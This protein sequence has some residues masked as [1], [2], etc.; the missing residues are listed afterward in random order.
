MYGTHAVKAMWERKKE[1]KKVRERET[2]HM[3]TNRGWKAFKS[4]KT[5]EKI[6]DQK[7]WNKKI[8]QKDLFFY[9][10]HSVFRLIL[11]F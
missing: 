6:L 10:R 8:F 5:R 11:Y 3:E 1:G 7:K 4:N 9:I 2:V